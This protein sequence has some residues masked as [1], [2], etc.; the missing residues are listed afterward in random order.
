MVRTAGEVGGAVSI[1]RVDIL[2]D[3]GCHLQVD[4]LPSVLQ[5]R[6]SVFMQ[7][8]LQRHVVHLPGQTPGE[9]PVCVYLQA[10]SASTMSTVSTVSTVSN[11]YCQYFVPDL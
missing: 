11:T 6:H 7:D 3:G 5:G 4:H 2:R 8:V 10:V 9:T 1:S